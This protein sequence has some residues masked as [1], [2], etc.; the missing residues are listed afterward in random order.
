MTSSDARR[1]GE[2]IAASQARYHVM[3]IRLLT[4][5]ACS[6]VVVDSQTGAEQTLMGESDWHR[7]QAQ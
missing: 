5:R 2:R 6:L 7:L 1:L 3:A 4:G